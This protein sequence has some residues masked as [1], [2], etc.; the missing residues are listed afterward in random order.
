M[1][2]GSEL[3]VT[4]LDQ[5]RPMIAQITSDQNNYENKMKMFSINKSEFE[6]RK[7]EAND[8]PQNLEREAM[9][10]EWQRNIDHKF[11]KYSAQQDNL[12]ANLQ[13]VIKELGETHN[14]MIQRQFMWQRKQALTGNDEALMK[15]LDEIQTWFD[16]LADMIIHTKSMVDT[17]RH[18]TLNYHVTDS[19]DAINLAYHGINS[20]FQNLIVSAFVV[21]RQ[22]PQVIRTNSQ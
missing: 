22:P 4:K 16:K 17:M 6:R 11:A 8:R 19:S 3:V 15:A 14:C 10:V 20:I 21:E 18:I 12:L 13:L 9:F 7:Q 5:L 1:D 2:A